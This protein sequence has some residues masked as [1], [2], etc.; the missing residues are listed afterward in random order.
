M[1]KNATATLLLILLSAS[2]SAQPV[3]RCGSEYSQSPCPQ[4]RVVDVADPR[5]EA[6]RA[7]RQRVLA[8]ERRLT[9]ELRRE[10]LADEARLTPTVAW[11]SSVP[12]AAV[13]KPT[14]TKQRGR[15]FKVRVSAKPP[16]PQV[17]LAAAPSTRPPRQK[18]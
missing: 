10:R 15:E 6:Q 2:A 11:R 3:Y 16:T 4:G 5:T 1:K 7:D 14:P 12:A 9:E 17:P 18:K 8:D 13:P